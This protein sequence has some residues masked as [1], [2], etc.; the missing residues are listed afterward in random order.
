MGSG[1]VEAT[2][3]EN[4]ATASIGWS[5]MQATKRPSFDICTTRIAMMQYCTYSLDN[6]RLYMLEYAN[7]RHPP[8]GRCAGSQLPQ[9]PEHTRRL[10][11]AEQDQGGVSRADGMPDDADR[12]TATAANPMNLDR[13]PP[14]CLPT[15]SPHR[16]IFVRFLFFSTLARPKTAGRQ[17][18]WRRRPRR[19]S[20]RG[21]L[22]DAFPRH[23]RRCGASDGG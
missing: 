6:R 22:G 15:H 14:P 5:D 18:R 11:M 16:L 2:K 12:V 10:T 8:R 7:S 9:K 1:V 3:H 20:D 19:D 13:E 21:E 17:C 4:R 23:S